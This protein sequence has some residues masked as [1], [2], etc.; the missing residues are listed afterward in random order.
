M[1]VAQ[2]ELCP[3][4]SRALGTG[5]WLKVPGPCQIKKCDAGPDASLHGKGSRQ[6]GPQDQVA[7][8]SRP[9]WKPNS[10]CIHGHGT[11]QG[12]LHQRPRPTVSLHLPHVPNL[13]NL[14]RL[15]LELGKLGPCL[16]IFKS[17][18]KSRL[19]GLSL[20]WRDLQTNVE[21]TQ[22]RERGQLQWAESL[23]EMESPSPN[24]RDDQ[25]GQGAV[26]CGLGSEGLSISLASP[27]QLDMGK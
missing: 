11:Q 2:G 25:G 3:E 15:L 12:R 16:A 10:L 19:R 8:A 13:S 21:H 14:I 7:K 5:R 23:W 18:S 17:C 6:I 4:P 1:G 20:P 24:P 26:Q 9:S 27:K 22:G